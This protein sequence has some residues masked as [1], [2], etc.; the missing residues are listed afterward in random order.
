MLHRSAFFASQALKLYL[1]VAIPLA[2]PSLGSD[3]TQSKRLRRLQTGFWYKQDNSDHDLMFLHDNT[4]L[5]YRIANSSQKEKIAE[6]IVHFQKG[7]N[8]N[9]ESTASGASLA[10]RYILRRPVNT[11][12]IVGFEPISLKAG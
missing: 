8:T 5:P 4:G 3:L 10:G 2:K 9:I 1:D 6:V 12:L 7:L 11:W